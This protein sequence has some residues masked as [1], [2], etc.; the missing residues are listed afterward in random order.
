LDLWAQTLADN[1]S[2]SL[3]PDLHRDF[4]RHN[5]C[6]TLLGL[7]CDTNF[8]SGLGVV[9]CDGA[10]AIVDL[11]YQNLKALL[12]AQNYGCPVAQGH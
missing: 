1:H 12:L 9:N 3:V 11:W 2:V 10:Q 8:S 7:D 4:Q 5:H 6:C